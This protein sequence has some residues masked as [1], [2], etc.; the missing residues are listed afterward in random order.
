MKGDFNRVF[1]IYCIST[2]A[3]R[4]SN[5]LLIYYFFLKYIKEKIK[6]YEWEFNKRTIER[7]KKAN[8]RYGTLILERKE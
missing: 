2:D 5:N 4:F 6:I 8:L 1:R 7:A 3:I